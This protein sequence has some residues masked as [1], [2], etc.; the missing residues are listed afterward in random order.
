MKD[1]VLFKKV[2]ANIA[3]I[4]KAN[5]YSI[6]KLADISEMKRSSLSVIEKGEINVTLSTLNKLAWALD[7]EVKEFFN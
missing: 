2:G 6:Q 5:G 7:V 1:K 3:R 4:R